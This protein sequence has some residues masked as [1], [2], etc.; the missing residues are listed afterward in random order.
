MVLYYS[1]NHSKREER[2]LT[3]GFHF[4][5]YASI[6]NLERGVHLIK[7]GMNTKNSVMSAHHNVDHNVVEADHLWP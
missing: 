1:I 6:S 2:Y 4:F 3:E 5:Y 7:V